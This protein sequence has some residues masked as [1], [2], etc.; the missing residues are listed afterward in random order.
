MRTRILLPVTAL[1]LSLAL[2]A[3]AENKQIITIGG[4]QVAK[5]AER[6]TFEGDQVVLHYSDQTT[7]TADM[8]D[9]VIVFTVANA[10]KELE[11]ADKDAPLSYYDLQGRLLKKAPRRGAYII[12]KGEKIVK[13]MKQ[14]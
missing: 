7:E 8:Q 13:V 6:L 9:V 5:T 14:N 11:S 10:L 12:K 3:N 4:Q 2:S 1:L